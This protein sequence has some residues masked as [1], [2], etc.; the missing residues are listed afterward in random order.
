MSKQI[1]SLYELGKIL[2]NKSLIKF[3]QFVIEHPERKLS[4]TMISEQT[5]ISKQNLSHIVGIL[6]NFGEFQP[7]RNFRA[8]K[9]FIIIPKLEKSFKSFFLKLIEMWNEVNKL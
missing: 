7:E 3:V 9:G 1:E 2:K 4:L 8:E 6:R 5:D